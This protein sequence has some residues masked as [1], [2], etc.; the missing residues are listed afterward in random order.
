MVGERGEFLGFETI[1]LAPIDK[2]LI[3]LNMLDTGEVDWINTYHAVVYRALAPHLDKDRAQWL[4]DQT[5]E[6]SVG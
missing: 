1:S 2:A 5:C 6:L 3:D 4:A